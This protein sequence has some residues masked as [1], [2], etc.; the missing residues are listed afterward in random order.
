MSTAPVYFEGEW[1]G[2][3]EAIVKAPLPASRRHEQVPAIAEVVRAITGQL[4]GAPVEFGEL[5]YRPRGLRDRPL[6]DVG[7]AVDCK[8][9]EWVE[10]TVSPF[11]WE[12]VKAKGQLAL[13]GVNEGGKLV[14]VIATCGL[15]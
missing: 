10:T 13:A 4:P 5:R 2:R 9:L 1:W 11:R 6:K 14:A 12:L 3:Q 15:E 7:R 8:Y